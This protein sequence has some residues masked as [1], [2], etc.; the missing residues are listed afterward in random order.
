M[1]VKDYIQSLQD[2][3]KICVEKIGS[4][5]WYWSF[6]SEEKRI[7]ESQLEKAMEEQAN[8]V[9]TLQELQKKVK[10]ASSAREDDDDMLMGEG[11]DRSSLTLRHNTLTQEV[12]A[13]EKELAS[14]S[15][16]DPVEVEKKRE[17]VATLKLQ[18]DKWTDQILSI[19]DWV[20]QNLVNDKDTMVMVKRHWYGEDYDEEESGL[21]AL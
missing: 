7:K 14:Y 20:K 17:R 16:N 3:N 19:E 8:V 10:V 9:A 12:D 6:A 4:G 11:E 15:Q 21:R 1:H 5:N 13:L 2:D 18:T